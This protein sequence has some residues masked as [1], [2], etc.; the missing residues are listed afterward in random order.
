MSRVIVVFLPLLFTVFACAN[1]ACPPGSE[2]TEVGRCIAPPSDPADE[3]AGV[4]EPWLDPDDAAMPSP[5]MIELLLPTEPIRVVRGQSVMVP[6]ELSATAGLVGP[7]EVALI[8]LPEGVSS[9][10][11]IIGGG[12]RTGELRI[13][14]STD[15]RMGESHVVAVHAASMADAEVGFEGAI[16]LEVA[17]APGALDESFDS[18]G[19]RSDAPLDGTAERVVAV[20]IDGDQNIVVAGNGELLDRA[21]AFVSWYAPTG[22]LRTDIADGGTHQVRTLG[23]RATRVHGLVAADRGVLLSMDSDRDYAIR[24]LNEMGVVDTAWGENGEARRPAG[25]TGASLYAHRTGF[26]VSGGGRVERYHVHGSLDDT[27]AAAGVVSGLPTHGEQVAV[28]PDGGFVVGA[29]TTEGFRFE[30]FDS[31]GRAQLAFGDRGTT[32]VAAPS[33]YPLIREI[34]ALPDGGFVAVANTA[35]VSGTDLRAYLVR[36]SATGVPVGSFGPHGRLEHVGGAGE[37]HQIYGVTAVDDRVYVFGKQVRSIGAPRGFVAAYTLDGRL[38]AE[39]GGAGISYVGELTYP[40]AVA[41]DAESGR[42]VLACDHPLSIAAD[43]PRMIAV[44]RIWL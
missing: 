37:E 23:A 8:E 34:T 12:A 39:F 9:V 7:V 27:F 20:A 5:G 19:V 43:A 36:V 33:G 35:T 13:D 14:V 26:L 25:S 29:L 11:T 38:D 10:P 3:D 28:F 6:F 22:V 31:S 40:R 42:L 24:R 17:G 16:T 41:H 15:A 21:A 18:D 2:G 30:R 44:A 32:V 1:P 4:V